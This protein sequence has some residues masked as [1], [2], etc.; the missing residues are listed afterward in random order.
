MSYR[1][2][3]RTINALVSGKVQDQSPQIEAT[4]PE[5]LNQPFL[6]GAITERP[7]YFTLTYSSNDKSW[8]INGGALH[9]IPKSR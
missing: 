9:G 8:V 6:G 4:D 7:I 2:L 5:E 3:A 1:D